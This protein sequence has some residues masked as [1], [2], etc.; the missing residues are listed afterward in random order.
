MSKS[1]LS[2][3]FAVLLL[4][5]AFATPL[6]AAEYKNTEMG[7]TITYP[8]GWVIN[9]SDVKET[10]LWAGHT[11]KMPWLLVTIMNQP[12]LEDARKAS[13]DLWGS[14]DL[15]FEP[16][17]EIT[18]NNGAKAYI[19]SAKY[20][21]KEGYNAEGMMLATQKNGKWIFVSVASCPM[22]DGN[23][24]MDAYLPMVKQIKFD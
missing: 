2:V 17:E 23:F 6:Y 13:F 1:K 3:L 15:E 20:T 19:S 14:T 9:K 10:V 7:F 21:L 18:L 8:D 16:V 22:W 12:K 5:V 4:M 11:S 24:D